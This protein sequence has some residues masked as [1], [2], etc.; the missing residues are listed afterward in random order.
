M[1]QAAPFLVSLPTPSA[2]CPVFLTYPKYLAYKASKILC[3]AL[4]TPNHWGS[5]VLLGTTGQQPFRDIGWPLWTMVSV[6][7]GLLE[8]SRVPN[9]TKRNTGEEEGINKETTIRIQTTTM[10]TMHG[11]TSRELSNRSRGM[12]RRY[13]SSNTQPTPPPIMRNRQLD[14]PIIMASSLQ[15]SIAT[16][17]PI[18]Q[19]Q[20]HRVMGTGHRATITGQM[21][22]NTRSPRRPQWSRA[23]RPR[24]IK[25]GLSEIKMEGWNPRHACLGRR[26]T[27]WTREA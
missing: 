23:C 19:G 1:R 8:G 24:R 12:M 26:A 14:Q 22:A 17:I 3:A 21:Q 6:D 16:A 4:L 5:L 2:A 10:R 11:V 7:K 25:Q 27:I 9:L 18:I 20:V 15:G 13:R